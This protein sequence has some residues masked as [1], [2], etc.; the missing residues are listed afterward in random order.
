MVFNKEIKSNKLLQS[1]PNFLKNILLA[2]SS[3]GFTVSVTEG[4]ATASTME[5]S[6]TSDSEGAASIYYTNEK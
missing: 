1:D 2:S 5:E 6:A 4:A 3:A